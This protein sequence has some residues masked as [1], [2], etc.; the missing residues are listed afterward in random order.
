VSA[1]YGRHHRVESPGG[2]R[3]DVGPHELRVWGQ[4]GP[5]LELGGA[6]TVGPRAGFE[7]AFS[8]T[9]PGLE[10][11]LLTAFVERGRDPA[12]TGEACFPFLPALDL[13]AD[14]LVP[15]A[16]PARAHSAVSG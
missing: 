3:L 16:S 8:R 14:V 10:G 5:Q 7:L 1:R 11:T 6:L 13:F 12:G 9:Q 2:T 4:P 15:A